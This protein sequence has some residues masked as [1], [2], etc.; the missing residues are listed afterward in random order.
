MHL[1]RGRN[2]TVTLSAAGKTN[3]MN[4]WYSKRNAAG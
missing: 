4:I 1:K 2:E 3:Q